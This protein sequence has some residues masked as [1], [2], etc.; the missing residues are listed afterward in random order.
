MRAF[1][2]VLEMRAFTERQ[3]G[4]EIAHKLGEILAD[5]GTENKAFCIVHDQASNMQ[6]SVELLSEERGWKSL[7]CAAHCL[8]LCVN[9]RLSIP[10]IDRLVGAA[11]KLVS[12]FHHNRSTQVTS[13]TNGC[14]TKYINHSMCN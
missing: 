9:A 4:S 3:T 13:R 14:A 6:L 2:F 1:A 10:A 5:F 8:Q 12:H 11:R 7:K